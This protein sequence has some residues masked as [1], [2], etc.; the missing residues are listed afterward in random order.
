MASPASAIGST[1]NTLVDHAEKS[2]AKRYRLPGI[3]REGIAQLSLLE[4]ALWPL[5]GGA[6]ETS[7]FDTSY[8]FQ[9]GKE[10]R[11]A[12]VSVYA[13]LGMQSIDEYVLWGLLGTSLS[14]TEK[15]HTL[16]ATPYWM[17]QQL[18]MSIGGFQYDQL[19]ASLERL[20]TIAYQNTA[21]YN[22]VTQ[23]HER[24]TFHFLSAYLPT[25]GRGGGVDPER[26]WRVEWS[27][28]FYEMCQ[29]TGGTLLF[30]LD[31]YRDLSPAARRLFLK[32]KDRFWRSKRVFMNVDDLTINGLG[33]SADRP[34]KKRKFDLTACIRELLDQGIIELGPGQIEVRDLFLKRGTGLYVVQFFP[35]SYFRQPLSGRATGQ[36][37]AITNDP[38]YQP[39]RN[40]GVDEAAIRRIFKKHARGL[41][42][43]WVRV[44][45]AAMHEQPTGFPGFKTSP[46]AFL[47]DAIQNQRMPPDWS[48]AHE[49]D[50][51]RRSWEVERHSQATAESALREQ[52]LKERNAALQAYLT[53]AEGKTQLTNYESKFREFYETVE[54]HRSREAA[55]EATIA[56][57][58]REHI[59]FPD[60][61][62]WMLKQHSPTAQ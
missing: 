52:H 1:E 30:D 22:P 33:F 42:Q 57:I 17:I 11:E 16:M 21:F 51:Q 2:S 37:K 29:A 4:T 12:R 48:F 28:H 61:G 9:V 34:L 23:Q 59:Q 32:L 31:V 44:T 6:R 62:V 54:P 35:G 60:F 55:H 19:R 7:M 5:K 43:R 27:P 47:V 13:P 40:I 14:H 58:E 49:K 20:A 46:A 45:D 3:A 56:K 53:T 36:Q 15:N 39:L 41:I 26:A 25:K 24:A 38:L 50:R 8:H 10:K 18:G